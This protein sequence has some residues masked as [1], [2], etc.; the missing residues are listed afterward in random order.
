MTVIS[1]PMEVLD[2][3][4]RCLLSSTFFMFGSGTFGL[5]PLQQGKA[6]LELLPIR[7]LTGNWTFCL[8]DI[9]PGRTGEV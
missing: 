3:S 2:Y 6:P 7:H 4:P 9:P 8:S 1:N 5:F